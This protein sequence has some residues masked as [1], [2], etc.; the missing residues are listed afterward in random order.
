MKYQ[1]EILLPPLRLSAHIMEGKLKITETNRK[2]EEILHSCLLF[3][4]FMD[5]YRD[6]VKRNVH[7]LFTILYNLNLACQ[8]V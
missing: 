2:Y 3:C 4:A 5:F 1:D 8:Q 7:V 6:V